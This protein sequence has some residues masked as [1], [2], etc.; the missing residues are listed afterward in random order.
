MA[1]YMKDSF[2]MIFDMVEGLN[3]M[4]MA[5]PTWDNFLKVELKD[6]ESFTGRMERYMKVNGTKE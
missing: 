6:K 3:A 5:T 2:D 1:E 4:P